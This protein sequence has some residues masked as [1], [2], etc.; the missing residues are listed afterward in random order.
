[1][2]EICL[3][4]LCPPAVEE[5]L[6]D[7]LLMVPEAHVFTRTS[8]SVHGVEHRHPDQTEQVLGYARATAVQVIIHEREFAPLLESLRQ[9]FR[10][11]GLRYWSTAVLAAGEIV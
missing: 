6:L 11:F 5:Q 4:L 10:G 9:Q 3:T 8:T 1:M 7:L 2:S